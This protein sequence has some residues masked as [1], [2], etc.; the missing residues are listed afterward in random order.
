M[1]PYFYLC[2]AGLAGVAVG[3]VI[4]LHYGNLDGYRRGQYEVSKNIPSMLLNAKLQGAE[5]ERNRNK[6]RNELDKV[7]DVACAIMEAKG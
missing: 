3:Y 7:I 2:M 4:G 5:A 1:T 6:N